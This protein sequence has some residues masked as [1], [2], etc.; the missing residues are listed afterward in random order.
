MYA[1][2]PEIL[3]DGLL[4]LRPTNPEDIDAQSEC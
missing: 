3:Q 4:K 1:P 2:S